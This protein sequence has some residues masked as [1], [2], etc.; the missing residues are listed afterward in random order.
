MI[1]FECDYCNGAHQKILDRLISTNSFQSLTYGDDEFSLSAN[2]KIKKACKNDKLDIYFLMGGTQTNSTIIDSILQSFQSVI[3]VDCSHINVH[4]S[5]AIESCGHKVVTLQSYNGKLRSEDL[6]SYLEKFY[7]DETYPHM[8]QPGLVYITFPTEWG[9]IYSHN[10]LEKISIVCKKYHLPLYFDGARLG[11]G[12]VAEENDITLNDLCSLTDVFYIGGTKIGA[13]CGEAAVF[14]HNN[15][16]PNFFTI[17]KQHGAVLAK[18]RL[19]GIQFDELFTDNLYFE[20]STHAVNMAMQ[21]KEIFK[22]KGYSFYID[23]PTNQQF[24]IIKNDRIEELNK[25]FLFSHIAPYNDN[26]TIC[27]FVTS[28]ATK[29]EEIQELK[30]YL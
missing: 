2:E 19:L 15:S 8:T 16:N 20:I 17:Q 12:L 11:Y 1:S 23:S 5:G 18:G 10:E 24:V 22:N 14:T 6:E 7:A 29:E 3:A 13:L 4:E 26:S 30:K 25:H 27:R 9:T 28:W 21:M